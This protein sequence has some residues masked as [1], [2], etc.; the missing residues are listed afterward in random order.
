ML[1]GRY[2][3]K[4][5]KGRVE[6]GEREREAGSAYPSIGARVRLSIGYQNKERRERLCHESKCRIQ[7]EKERERVERENG[8]RS[9]QTEQMDRKGW[10]EGVDINTGWPDLSVL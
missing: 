2:K 4:V 6:E 9:L 5:G 3:S 1:S 7:R 8:I 10:L